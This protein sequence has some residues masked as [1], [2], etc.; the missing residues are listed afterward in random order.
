MLVHA[1]VAMEVSNPLE[2]A[3][4][5]LLSSSTSSQDIKLCNAAFILSTS[6]SVMCTHV[7]PSFFHL[8]LRDFILLN[9]VIK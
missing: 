2:K 3:S 4:K 1:V 6:A 9:F 8:Q 7:L 5:G